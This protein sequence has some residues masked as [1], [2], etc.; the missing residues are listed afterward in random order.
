MHGSLLPVADDDASILRLSLNPSLI[1][2]NSPVGH[3]L[4]QII[5]RPDNLFIRG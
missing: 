3:G 5:Y 1:D 2:S 4:L